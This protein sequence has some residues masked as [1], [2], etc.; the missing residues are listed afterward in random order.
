M[1]VTALPFRLGSEA[2]TAQ[3]EQF[4]ARQE[5]RWFGLFGSFQQPGEA[6]VSFKDSTSGIL[7]GG[8]TDAVNGG[9]IAAGFDGAFVLA[10]LGHYETNVVVTLELSI[11][12]LDLAKN[13]H[14]LAWSAY[15]M[16]TSKRFAFAEARLINRAEP[17]ARPV[18][19]ASAMVAPAF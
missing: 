9:V 10:G 5:V 11:K 3:L 8:G 15:I 6:L 19:I 17:D 7:G 16:R 18:A 2:L 12:F 14:S 4:N 13:P 1:C